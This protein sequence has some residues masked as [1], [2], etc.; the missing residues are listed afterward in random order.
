MSR[1]LGFLLGLTPAGVRNYIQ[2]STYLSYFVAMVL[3]FGLAFELPL[4]MV[5]LNKVGILTHER[6]RKW[7]RMMIF[8]VFVFCGI[9]SPGPADHADARRAV[10]GAG[11][12]GR[13]HHL[14]D[15][16]AAGPSAGAVRRAQRR[17]GVAARLR[18]KRAG[19]RRARPVA[20]LGRLGPARWAVRG[21]DRGPL[22][23]IGWPLRRA[24]RTGT[25]PS[26]GAWRRTGRN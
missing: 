6:F 22:L 8:L 9:A 24:L 1:G 2:V 4:A 19:G 5:M 26:S 15:R 10:R 7:R 12:G 17:R 25:P 21:A 20:G 23:L 13:G 18:R 14:G 3:G 16:P 11:R